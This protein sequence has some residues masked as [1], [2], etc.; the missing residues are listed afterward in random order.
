[1]VVLEKMEIGEGNGEGPYQPAFTALLLLL[2]DF[3]PL[4]QQETLAPRRGT[5]RGASRPCGGG[6][7]VAGWCDLDGGELEVFFG[8]G[9]GSAGKVTYI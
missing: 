5:G 3:Q 4:P 2:S 8:G 1:M 6:V 9:A 7:F